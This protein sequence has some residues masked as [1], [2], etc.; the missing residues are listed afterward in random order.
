MVSGI[1]RARA[2]RFNKA[3]YL[4]MPIYRQYDD[5]MESPNQFG[6]LSQHMNG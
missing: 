4:H 1:G 6:L 3:T 5:D 2:L